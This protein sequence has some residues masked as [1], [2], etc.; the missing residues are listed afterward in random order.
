MLEMTHRERVMA[1]LNHRQPDRTPI[2]F[3]GTFTTTIFQA[4][5]ERLKDHLGLEHETGIYSKTRRLAVPD[6]SVLERFDVDTRMVGL[7]A[8]A[9]DQHEIDDDTYFDEWGT[10][11][12]KADDGHYLYVDGPFFAQKKPGQAGLDKL[13]NGAWP[14]PDNPGYYEGLLERSQAQRATGCAVILNMPIGIIHQGQFLRGFGDWLKD[15][16]K[17]REFSARMMDIIADRWIAVA[18]NALDIVGDN[19]DIVFLGDDL[20]AQ[21]APLFDP[22]IYRELIKPRHARMLAAVK[23]KADVKVLYHSCGAVSGLIDDLIDIGVDAINPVQVAANDM[24][25]ADLKVRFGDRITFW[26]GIDTQ[27]VLPFGTGEDVRAEVR[28]TIDI[29][30]PGGGFV[31]NSV[32]NIQGDVAAENIVAMFDEA[33]LYDSPYSSS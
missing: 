19:I 2:D 12:K 4:A 21:M 27:G 13:D 24:N 29:L 9:G 11:W 22:V 8:Y 30:A 15:L 17:N 20:A 3:G 28:R 25:P 18:E 23:A 16:Y 1:A 31:L 5:Y 6:V 32:H 7:G 33:R 14:D 26:G 10:T